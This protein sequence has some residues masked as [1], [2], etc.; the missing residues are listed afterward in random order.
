M[1]VLLTKSFL[2]EDLDYISERLLKGITLIHPKGFDEQSLIP[3]MPDADVLLGSFVTDNM[4]NEAKNLKFIQVPWVG[5]DNLDFELLQNH[6]VTVCNS[7]SNATAVA[8]HAVS[9]MLDAAKKISYHDRLLRQGKWNRVIPE[10]VNEVSPFSAMIS[11]SKVGIIGFGAIGKKIF[12]I[13]KGFNC[14]FKAFTKDPVILAE[15]GPDL[16]VFSPE[17]IYNEIRELDFIFVTVPLTL[18]TR[19]LIDKKFLSSMNGNAVLINISR[20]E[21]MNEEDLYSALKNKTI[22]YAAIDTWFNYP[23]R[24]NPEAFPSVEFSYHLLDNV[25]LS[26]HRAGYVREGFPHLDDAIENLNRYYQG[27][28][29]INV[30]S[31]KDRY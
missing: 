17:H 11:N 8:E 6:N 24:K 22:A 19:Q 31:L 4:L 20:G 28:P 14:N 10:Q 16:S 26:P 29:L 21:V 3:L 2:N 30:V 18:Q 27:K 5:I 15:F 13:L 23:S 7:H 12:H 1:R 25:V 9:L